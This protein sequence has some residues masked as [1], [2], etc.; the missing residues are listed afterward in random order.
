[1][2]T[3]YSFSNRRALILLTLT[4]SFLHTLS[5]SYNT[6]E[7]NGPCESDHI[8]RCETEQWLSQN[9]SV[10]G[11][12]VLCITREPGSAS[13]HIAFHREGLSDAAHSGHYISS[14]HD[15]KSLRS[16]LER[17]LRMEKRDALREGLAKVEQPNLWGAFSVA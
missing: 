3:M 4:L 12:H 9:G 16:E 8:F 1:M 14:S 2:A 15:F 13:L 11:Y 17:V 5:A 7:A 6:C 10:P